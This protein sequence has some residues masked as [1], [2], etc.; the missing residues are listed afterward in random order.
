[1]TQGPFADFVIKRRRII[2]AL[3]LLNLLAM[4]F[5]ASHIASPEE[6]T[7]LFPPDYPKVRYQAAE[8][9]FEYG[10]YLAGASTRPLLRTT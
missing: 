6:V 4:G 5:L 10:Q 8:F 3:T 2:V 9:N 7:Q 1:M